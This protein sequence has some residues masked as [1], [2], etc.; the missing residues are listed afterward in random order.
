MTDTREKNYLY[1]GLTTG[2][3][4]IAVRTHEENKALIETI[5]EVIHE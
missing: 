3:C 5:R 4:R 1:R 2:D